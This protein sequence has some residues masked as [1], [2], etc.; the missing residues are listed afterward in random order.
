MKKILPAIFFFQSVC[1][2]AGPPVSHD[3]V[4]D[5]S[6]F[7]LSASQYQNDFSSLNDQLK[8]W[9]ANKSFSNTYYMFGIS[10]V[11]GKEIN[12]RNGKWDGASSLEWMPSQSVSIGS[13]DSV[14]YRMKGWHLMTSSFGKDLIP[15]RTVALVIAPGVDWGTTKLFRSAGG[16]ETKYKN[17][18]V[19]PLVRADLRFVFGKF[20]IGGRALYRYDITNSIWKRR[21]DNIPVMA[22]TR[23][24]GL[25]LLAF[26]GIDVGG[27]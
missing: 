21:D 12:K 22:G 8:G 25:G 3:W 11:S 9:G 4:S 17:P 16:K 15:G 27:E 1:L 13:S 23:F 18:F 2:F 26:I 10:L 19:S 24:T 7:N 20:S 6:S 5:H 14:S